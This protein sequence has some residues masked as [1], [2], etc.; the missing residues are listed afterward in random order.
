MDFSNKDTNKE[1][2]NKGL[3]YS[4]KTNKREVIE[5]GLPR[6]GIKIS[7]VRI[8]IVLVEYIDDKGKILS[9]GF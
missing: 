2:E 8:K 4:R 7:F 6:N 1:F 3:E 5:K 9:L